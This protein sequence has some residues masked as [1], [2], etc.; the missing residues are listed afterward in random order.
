[1]IL[2]LTC[3]QDTSPNNNINIKLI[4]PAIPKLIEAPVL[5]EAHVSEVT[6]SWTSWDSFVDDS[7][8]LFYVVEYKPSSHLGNDSSGWKTGATVEHTQFGKVTS[9]TISSLMKNTFYEFRVVPVLKMP[10][11]DGP[12][13]GGASPGSVPFKTKCNGEWC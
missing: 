6:I 5:L 8:Y 3:D 12:L 10:E 9:T 11:H 7:I 1:M 4:S 2:K 13:R